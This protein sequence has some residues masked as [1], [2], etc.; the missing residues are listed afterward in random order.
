[1]GFALPGQQ[2]ALTEAGPPRS[3]RGEAATKV[4]A[5]AL[6]RPPRVG[7]ASRLA[8]KSNVCSTENDVFVIISS[9]ADNPLVVA[10]RFV[11]QRL[12]D[13]PSAPDRTDGVIV[14]L[15]GLGYRCM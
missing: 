3:Q 4:A 2:G 12:P 1:V 8:K 10:L 11:Q 15:A 7:E 9:S 14:Q 6:A 5:R 13:A